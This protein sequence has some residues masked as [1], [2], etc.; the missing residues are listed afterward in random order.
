MKKQSNANDKKK[1][2]AVYCR[3][4]TSEQGKG[5]FSSLASQEDMIRKYCELNQWSVYDVYADT[6]TG[7]TLERKQLDRL[8]QDAAADKINIIA[9]TKLD[10]I[11]RSIKDFLDLDEILRQLNID[12]VVTTQ[13]I[14]TTTA[15]G[16]MQRNI[17]L[18]F[19]EFE[20]DMIAERT[21]EKLYS[22]AQQGYWGGGHAPLGYDVN[23]KKLI[24]NKSEAAL[25]RRIYK[26]YYEEPSTSRV[27]A[28]LNSEG[29][30][31]KVRKYDNGRVVGGGI[32]NKQHVRDVLR[33]NVYIGKIKYKDELFKGLHEASV[34]DELFN[35]VQKRFDE[36]AKNHMLTYDKS[37]LILLGLTKCGFCKSILTTS[38]ASKRGNRYYY[39]KCSK[40]THYSGGICE[41]RDLPAKELEAFI[42][43]L[44]IHMATED[45]FFKAIAKQL[46]TN[47]SD[48]V[49]ELKQKLNEI[50]GNLSSVTKEVDNLVKS[51][52]ISPDLKNILSVTKR[53]QENEN[54]KK[55]LEEQIA[56]LQ[57]QID[58][59]K[60]ATI[61]TTKLKSIY[62]EFKD[63]Y[64][65]L[66]NQLKAKVAKLLIEAIIS[67]IKKR[68]NGGKLE[69]LLRGDGCIREVWDKIKDSYKSGKLSDMIAKSGGNVKRWGSISRYRYNWL[70]GPDSNQRQGG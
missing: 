4:S 64:P 7:T 50:S 30:R 5:D 56:K 47:S 15:A 13:N 49:Q 28:R 1:W 26:Y 16:K 41:A 25:V 10:R 51:I 40:K 12:I 59:R 19:A 44:I 31:T 46:K 61:N 55:S 57:V 62:K 69:I 20:R 36:S 54:L 21:R 52:E 42:E 70:P 45:E 23:N 39:Y 38:F 68:E 9:V 60:K 48:D 11:S 58:Q 2:V 34:D 67:H 24:V 43:Q 29:Y 63:I 27:T 18:A 17:M 66:P 35:K 6:K 33:N 22:Q 3:V 53:I 37:E 32:F 14:D 65:K 8:L